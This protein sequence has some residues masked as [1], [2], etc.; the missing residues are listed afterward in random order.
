MSVNPISDGPLARSIRAKLEEA[1]DPVELVVTDQSSEH[2]GHVGA[3]GYG[4]ES[5][6]HVRLVSERL[7]DLPRVARSRVVHD[8]LAEEMPRIHALSLDLHEPEGGTKT[9]VPNRD[10][11]TGKN[12]A[13]ATKDTTKGVAFE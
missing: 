5:H 3:R 13:W 12:R 10:P 6:F 2:A 8:I 7:R 9:G 1:F 4:A 11:E